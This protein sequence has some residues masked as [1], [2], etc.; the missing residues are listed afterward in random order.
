MQSVDGGDVGVIQRG[1][2]LGLALE[3]G[4]AVRVVGEGCRQELDGDLAVE[5]GIDRLPHTA[6]PP[7]ADFLAELVVQQCLTGFERH[8]RGHV[9]PSLPAS[10]TPGKAGIDLTARTETPRG[11]HGKTGGRTR[12]H[13]SIDRRGLVS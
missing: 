1:Q 2:Q 4:Q 5:G 9:L 11:N 3:A 6:H 12:G 10:W 8:L 7:L 13:S